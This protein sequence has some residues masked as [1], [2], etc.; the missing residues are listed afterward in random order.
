MW[1]K[2]FLAAG[3]LIVFALAAA[4]SGQEKLKLEPL[5]GDL[6]GFYSVAGSDNGKKYAGV[7]Q[8]EKHGDI[9]VVQWSIRGN[10]F[11]GVGV[12][13]GDTLAV[14]WATPTQGGVSRGVN[15]YRIESSKKL[16]GRWSALPGN[17][18]V[19]TETLSWLKE[20][21]ADEE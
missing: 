1:R 20:L 17:G 15:V 3:C 16:V 7:C 12:R 13:S 10:S 18:L 14:G 21:S 2:M 19:A 6:S 5:A 9:Y 8:L 11:T 4:S